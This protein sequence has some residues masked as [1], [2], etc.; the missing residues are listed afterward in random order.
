MYDDK[1]VLVTLPLDDV[2]DGDIAKR[3]W[4]LAR[5]AIYD[6]WMESAEKGYGDVPEK[7]LMLCDLYDSAEFARNKAAHDAKENAR[8]E[9]NGV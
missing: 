9:R 4:S 3:F 6:A 5:K 8:K 2:S 1:E 7:L